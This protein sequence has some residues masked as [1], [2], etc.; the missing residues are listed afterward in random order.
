MRKLLLFPLG[1]ILLISFSCSKED[2]SISET[3]TDSSSSGSSPHTTFN[4]SGS[5]AIN[6]YDSNWVFI[7]NYYAPTELSILVKNTSNYTLSTNFDASLLKGLTNNV[8]QVAIPSNY[9]S[10]NIPGTGI[11]NNGII[12][13]YNVKDSLY[14]KVL[15]KGVNKS[16]VYL[17]FKGK[18]TSSY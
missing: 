3:V 14:Y 18:L 8:I 12:N 4:Y 6:K 10:T 11:F 9:F 2:K 16:N 15:Y 17:D 13:G 5:F 1:L 7:N